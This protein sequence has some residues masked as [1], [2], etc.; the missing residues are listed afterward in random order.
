MIH[1]VVCVAEVIAIDYIVVN[2]ISLTDSGVKTK[3]SALILA[4]AANFIVYLVAP[5]YEMAIYKRSVKHAV[6]M[7]FNFANCKY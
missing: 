7:L 5:C 4:Q 1:A 2:K 3:G 6:H